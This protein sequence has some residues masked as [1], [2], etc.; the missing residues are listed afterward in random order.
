MDQNPLSEKARD[1]ILNGDTQGALEVLAPLQDRAIQVL[2]A[3]FKAVKEQVIKNTISFDDA[4]R[5]YSQINDKLLQ[6]IT[7]IEQVPQGIAARSRSRWIIPV[8]AVL[9][10]LI[11]GIWYWQKTSINPNC[12][13]FSDQKG[14]KIAFF[15]FQKISGSGN[16]NT[17]LAV[18]NSISELTQ[19]H[20]IEVQVKLYKTP[21][22]TVLSIDEKEDLAEG[23]GADLVIH[24]DFDATNND[25]LRLKLRYKF[26]NQNPNSASA[27]ET[28]PHIGAMNT[29]RSV[30]DVVLSI[31]AQIAVRQGKNNV[32]KT[33]LSK[34]K[35]PDPATE[36]D[37]QKVLQQ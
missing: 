2:T 8:G 12:P 22:T 1:L 14:F 18:M 11:L 36:A 32:A 24:G 5:A 17:T 21:E 28:L 37:L 19:K 27:T 34:L 25:S 15:H 13:E 30:E 31:C 23:C 29:L 35:T 7:E 3:N 6:R 9:L 20:D 33:W 26:F 10:V 16:P 4:Q